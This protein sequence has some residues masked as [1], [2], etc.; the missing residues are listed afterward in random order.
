MQANTL[1][2]ARL[3]CLDILAHRPSTWGPEWTTKILGAVAQ[4]AIG[5]IL[6]ST[7]HCSDTALTQGF[8]AGAERQTA[9]GSVCWKQVPWAVLQSRR[10]SSHDSRSRLWKLGP[11]PTAGGRGIS[12]AGLVAVGGN[13]QDGAAL[14]RLPQRPGTEEINN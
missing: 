1:G 5:K 6:G 11:D 8:A 9:G 10:R 12:G 2:L 4:S 14:M 3:N 7:W 13:L